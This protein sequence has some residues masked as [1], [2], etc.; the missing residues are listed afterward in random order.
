MNHDFLIVNADTDS[1][2]FCKNDQTEFSVQEREYLL[3]EINDLMP[4]P[5]VWGDDGIYSRL[6]VLAAKNYIMRNEKGKI[7]YKGSS[8][9]S[10]SL[11]PALKDFLKEI[12]DSMLNDRN[13]YVEIYNK[14]VKM[15]HNITD[16]KPWC[17]KRT[18]SNK[19]MTND[20]ENEAKVMRAL[21]GTEYTEGDRV[22]LFFLDN[23]ELCLL[24]KFDGINYNKRKLLEKLYKATDRF[25]TV[26]DPNMFLN[27]S[28]KKKNKKELE[29]LLN[30]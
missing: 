28:L 24:E 7:T 15:I 8:L 18:I 21:E 30:G 20:R 12:I 25:S 5:L 2:S 3:K 11:E 27:Y 23:D 17:S 16:I 10:A 22:Y 19:T 9:K 29:E 6:I 4:D 14:H 26:L 13:D 1:I